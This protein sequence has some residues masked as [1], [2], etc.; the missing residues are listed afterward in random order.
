MAYMKFH[1]VLYVCGFFALVTMQIY[2]YMYTYF[3]SI[4]VF[5][6]VCV[7]VSWIILY[8]LITL[9]AKAHY[10]QCCTLGSLHHFLI[11]GQKCGSF[12]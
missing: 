6:S 8:N 2:L 11:E 7:I 1:V 4:P 9:T 3:H 10:R 5:F 12:H